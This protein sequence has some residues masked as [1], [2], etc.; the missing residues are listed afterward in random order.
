MISPFLSAVYAEVKHQSALTHSPYSVEY[1]F[2]VE[3][4][5]FLVLSKLCLSQPFALLSG[6]FFQTCVW[7][8]CFPLCSFNRTVFPPNIQRTTEGIV[9]CV[10]L[11]QFSLC[12]TTIMWSQR[13]FGVT[14]GWF[15]WV[16]MIISRLSRV[17]GYVEL[18]VNSPGSASSLLVYKI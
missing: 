18:S 7:I 6:Q 1:P 5:Q 11:S 16:W 15:M 14:Y 3:I 12:C 9:C 13:R 10:V 17:I 4:Q 8:M 2:S